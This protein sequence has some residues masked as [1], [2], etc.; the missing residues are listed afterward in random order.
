MDRSLERHIDER[1]VGTRQMDR[2]QGCPLRIRT[3]HLQDNLRR[4][5]RTRFARFCEAL[6][7]WNRLSEFRRARDDTLEEYADRRAR[8]T[9]HRTGYGKEAVVLRLEL[10]STN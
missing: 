4:A 10:R 7:P 2:P 3:S 5:R 1:L 9:H 6:V 8:T